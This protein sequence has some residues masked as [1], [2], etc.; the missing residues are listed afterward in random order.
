MITPSGPVKRSGDRVSSAAVTGQQAMARGKG[1][2]LHVIM[3]A[4]LT[5]IV[6][7]IESALEVEDN[8]AKVVK[9]RS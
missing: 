5:D 2:H 4:W 8:R 7:L 9:S 1:D 3:G 6:Q